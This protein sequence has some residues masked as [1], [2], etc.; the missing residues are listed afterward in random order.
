MPTGVLFKYCAPSVRS[1]L[2]TKDGVFAKC[3]DRSGKRLGVFGRDGDPGVC[4]KQDL[5]G[6]AF[7]SQNHGF[8]GKHGFKHLGG[9]SSLKDLASEKRD[10]TCIR[11]CKEFRDSL[12]C[13]LAETV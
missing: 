8:S 9:N 7:D 6:F 4:F 3:E 13:L 1:Q 5:F 10:Q 12:P 11:S 2:K